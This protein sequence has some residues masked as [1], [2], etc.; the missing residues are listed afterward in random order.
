[1]SFDL[2]VWHPHQLF[3][4]AEAGKVYRDL[5]ASRRQG[6]RAHP[7]VDA[8]YA[9][10]IR[11]QPESDTV[12]EELVDDTEYCPWS[13]A[14]DRSHGH[15]LLCCV[16]SQAARV[17]NLVGIRAAKH[18]LLV[19][20]PQEGRVYYPT[21]PSA[22]AKLPTSPPPGEGVGKRERSA[23]RDESGRLRAGSSLCERASE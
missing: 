12:P 10:L 1:M 3:S 23:K 20:D 19:Y 22:K 5:C 15:V 14:L 13:S 6:V 18:G 4:D 2:C 16:W 9:E 11:L 21:L 7:A 17:A 8:F